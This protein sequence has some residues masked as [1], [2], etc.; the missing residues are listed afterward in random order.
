MRDRMHA[1]GDAVPGSDTYEFRVPSAEESERK[2]YDE[3]QRPAARSTRR[4]AIFVAQPGTRSRKRRRTGSDKHEIRGSSSEESERDEYDD[5]RPTGNGVEV[6]PPATPEF[7]GPV[8]K[9]PGRLLAI[10][11]NLQ[12]RFPDRDP[13]FFDP[14]FGAERARSFQG[15]S[16]FAAEPDR[17][18]F[19]RS[20]LIYRDQEQSQA[21]DESMPSAV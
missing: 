9:A 2:E 5:A 7:G 20:N 13:K 16:S 11:R 18:T 1:G 8:P 14:L 19:V 21:N 10:A 17:R 3:A 12:T 4:R 15:A 6:P